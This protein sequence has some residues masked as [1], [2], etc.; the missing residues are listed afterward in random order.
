MV[1]IVKTCI[2]LYLCFF[3]III[4]YLLM[5]IDKKVHGGQVGAYC[6]SGIAKSQ[7]YSFKEIVYFG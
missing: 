7:C 2:I 3:I 4:E 5:I 6:Y 1:E